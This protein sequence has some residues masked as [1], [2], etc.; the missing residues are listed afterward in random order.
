M[1]SGCSYSPA[2]KSHWPVLCR[3]A[4][5][6]SRASRSQQPSSAAVMALPGVRSR[7]CCRQ[8][9]S[10]HTV[11]HT[12]VPPCHEKGRLRKFTRP[13]TAPWSRARIPQCSAAQGANAS[14]VPNTPLA[15][16]APGR[17]SDWQVTAALTTS[18]VI[19]A[20]ACGLTGSSSRNPLPRV[21]PTPRRP[22][23]ACRPTTGQDCFRDQGPRSEHGEEDPRKT[24]RHCGN[25]PSSRSITFLFDQSGFRLG[26]GV[27]A[28]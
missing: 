6:N 9:E 23:G 1:R 7:A 19:F 28:V 17:R 14:F 24:T 8:V 18:A 22:M 25:F 15:Q 26:C 4:T 5:S 10:C 13:C 11:Y 3:A 2:A 20:P 16:P 12:V 27:R 21:A